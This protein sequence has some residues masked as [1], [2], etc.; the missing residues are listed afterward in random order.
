[1]H[2]LFNL[3]LHLFKFSSLN[4][5]LPNLELGGCLRRIFIF[6]LLFC[7]SELCFKNS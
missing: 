2:S 4:V 7:S 3:K 6:L 5:V 1:M